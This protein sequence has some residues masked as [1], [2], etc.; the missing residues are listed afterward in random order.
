[1]L[2]TYRQY[3]LVTLLLLILISLAY[4]PAF[5]APFY[6]DD[7]SGILLNEHF[8]R[9]NF[10]SYVSEGWQRAVGNFS[11][12]LNA[13]YSK[14]LEADYRL[15]SFLLHLGSGVLIVK[16]LLTT[17]KPKANEEKLLVCFLGLLFVLHPL[18]SQA[19][20]YIVQRYTLLAAFFVIL[21]LF[22]YLQFRRNNSFL[23]L[24]LTGVFSFC[25]VFSK[26][27]A[28]VLPLL[29]VLVELFWVRR[30]PSTSVLV[31]FL[32]FML[33]GSLL[34]F[35][36]GV[37]WTKV[38]LLTRE[39]DLFSRI[40][41]F[42][43]Q[44]HVILY[45]VQKFLLPTDL[46]LHYSNTETVIFGYPQWAII[47][48]YSLL[49]VLVAYKGNRNVQF[50]FL[51][52]FAAHIIESSFI[53][54]KDL[55]FEHR[56]YLPNVGLL[57]VIFGL[58]KPLTLNKNKMLLLPGLVIITL[59]TVATHQR[60][61]QWT[62]KLAFM[63]N[64]YL[65]SPGNV[66]VINDYM[67]EL[68]KANEFERSKALLDEIFSSENVE[69][70]PSLVLNAIF[71]YLETDIKE[72]EYYLSI[73][74]QN[75]QYFLPAQRARFIFLI[76]KYYLKRDDLLQSFNYFMMA[77]QMNPSDIDIVRG[78]VMVTESLDMDTEAARYGALLKELESQQQ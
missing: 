10:Y 36:S 11:F 58:V 47:T 54:I 17:I 30:M 53:P 39:T 71:V 77:H 8:I 15:F 46:R 56:T 13:L 48:F 25:A 18:N 28:V 60:S 62:D 70:S 23:Y 33:A 6:F 20:I 38:D 43:K 63:E 19:V 75:Q 55:V 4:F 72:A 37:T 16:F 76:G 44:L 78:I 29:M 67:V 3:A 45:Y 32:L 26:Q 61:L 34:V 22:S 21:T 7:Y 49:A 74:Q 42:E 27:N 51:F 69:V 31:S 50:G 52:Y 12:V 9:G 41:Y 24:L 73:G 1:M 59:C 14:G 64:E 2:N 65:L 68:N 35:L 5:H 40:E 66:R 57:F